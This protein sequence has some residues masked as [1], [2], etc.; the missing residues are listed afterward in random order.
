MSTTETETT[1]TDNW[2]VQWPELQPDGTVIQSR[3][4]YDSE[5][6]ARDAVTELL[7]GVFVGIILLGP[8]NLEADVEERIVLGVFPEPEAPPARKAKAV[9]KEPVP[10]LLA[11]ADEQPEPGTGPHDEPSKAR[12]VAASPAPRK[13]GAKPPVHR[14]KKVAKP[15]L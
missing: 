3:A 5:Q 12:K 10:D 13:V 9:P 8:D 14:A 7:K 11:P 4:V 15:V 2:L 1:E 6:D